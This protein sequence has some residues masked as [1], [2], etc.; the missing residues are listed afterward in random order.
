MGYPHPDLKKRRLKRLQKEQL[1]ALNKD[2]N[3]RDKTVMNN[4][5]M[6][7][8]NENQIETK[9][10]ERNHAENPTVYN[11]NEIES[12]EGE[13]R[14]FTN[15]SIIKDERYIDKD[16]TSNEHFVP[17]EINLSSLQCDAKNK[18]SQVKKNKK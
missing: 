13:G 3:I 18:T 10:T 14:T 4:T 6:I 9:P 7:P 12:R 8:T 15:T 16:T 5:A 1:D 11:R 17:L 2:S